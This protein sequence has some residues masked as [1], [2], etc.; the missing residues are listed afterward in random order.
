MIGDAEDLKRAK[1]VTDAVVLARKGKK[2]GKPCTITGCGIVYT[3]PATNM[4]LWHDY[5]MSTAKNE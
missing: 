4:C 1:A 2:W 5:Q 3:N